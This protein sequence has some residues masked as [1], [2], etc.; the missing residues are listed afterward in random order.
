MQLQLDTSVDYKRYYWNKSFTDPATGETGLDQDTTNGLEG[1]EIVFYAGHGDPQG[2]NAPYKRSFIRLN[3]FS[4]G[5]G[6]VRYLF[7]VSCNVLAH[8]PPVTP[9]FTRPDL[10]D[11]RTFDSKKADDDPSHSVANVFYRW[12]RYYGDSTIKI[13]PLNKRLRLACGGSSAVGNSVAYATTLL[14]NYF[15]NSNF[16]PADSFLAALY[17]RALSEIPLC[18]SR[19]DSFQDSGL[20]DTEFRDDPL[21]PPDRQTLPERI[22]IEYPAPGEDDDPVA[23]MLASRSSAKLAHGAAGQTADSALPILVIKPPPSPDLLKGKSL[24]TRVGPFGFLG[25]SALDLQADIGLFSLKQAPDHQLPPPGLD[26]ICVE[27]QP[28]SGSMI[29]SWRPTF[30]GAARHLLPADTERLDATGVAL[31]DRLIEGLPPAA[32]GESPEPGIVMGPPE[33]TRMKVDSVLA[34][35]M[36]SEEAVGKL[37]TYHHEPDRCIY[38]RQ[39][40]YYQKGNL[41][42]RIYGES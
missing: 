26:E 18:I 5:D 9:D 11:A 38:V 35:D 29:Y 32:S 28:T 16:G 15:L 6:K 4:L 23:L 20:A 17:N 13:S 40:A 36:M 21:V 14:W 34:K 7:M 33:T 25:S 3:Q 42:V 2:F 8:G 1:Y 30:P 27:R 37:E 19:G 10:F 12:G 24:G 39:P 41:A 31:L 22:Y